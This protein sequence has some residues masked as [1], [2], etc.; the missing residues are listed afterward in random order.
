MKIK[1]I[2]LCLAFL[3]VG[4]IQAQ[5][6]ADEEAINKLIVEYCKTEAAGDMEAQAKLMKADRIWIGPAGSGRIT[7]QTMNIEKQ[8]AQLKVMEKVAK[9]IRWFIDA[10]D[11]I[12]RSYGNGKVAVASFYLYRKFILPSDII[13]PEDKRE[14]FAS[15]PNPL[16]VTHVLEKDGVEWKI[17]HTHLSNLFSQSKEKE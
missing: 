4:L 6:K 17:V 1:G 14:L 16:V 7:N 3:L 5:D 13:I 8:Q 10:R 12:I 9:G 15:Q 11:I 2:V